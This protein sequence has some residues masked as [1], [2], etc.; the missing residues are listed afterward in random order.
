[1]A[2]DEV[3]RDFGVPPEDI[4][5]IHNAVDAERFSEERLSPLREPARREAGVGGDEILF[6]FLD[7]S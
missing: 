6:L 1:M 3:V 7:T 2:R 5:V 4:A